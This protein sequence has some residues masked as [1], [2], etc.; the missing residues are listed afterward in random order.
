[1]NQGPEW[2][3]AEKPTIDGLKDLGYEYLTTDQHDKNR[4][5]DNHVIFR[6]ILI[7]SIQRI[8]N[9]SKEDATSAYFELLNQ[10]NNEEWNKILRGNYSR[11]V[12]GKSKKQTIKIIDYKN[13]KNNTFTVTN[14]LY[15]KAQK[16]RIPDI[17]VYIN[18]IPVVVI[19]AK[20]PLNHKDKTGEAFEQIKQ[21]ERD[22]P[23]LFYSNVF[24]VLTDGTNCLYGATGSPSQFYGT[25]K[26]PY[27]KSPNDFSDALNLGLWC[28][29]EPSRFLDLIAHYIVF[30]TKDGKTIKKIC[31]YQQFRAV[32]KMVERVVD[33][34]HKQG[35]IWHTQGSGKSLTMVF[36]ALKLKTHLNIISPQLH[37]PNI[38]VLTDRVDLDDQISK[39][40]EAC[41][42][43]NPVRVD[44]IQDLHKLIRSG[45]DGL[46]IL[47]TIFKFQG[48]NKPIE[49]SINWIVLVDECHRTQEKDLGA[50]LRATLPDS[51]FFGF[52]GTPIKKN[53][54]DTYQN[55]GI[56]GEGY[57]DKYGIDDAVADGATVPIYFTSRKT[58]WHIDEGKLDI[59]F[60]QWFGN[61][62]EEQLEKTKKKG[63][64]LATIIKH[65]QRV[66]LIAYD[67]WTHF[68]QYAIPDGL[69]AQIVGFDREAVVLYKQALDKIIAEDFH[70]QGISIEKAESMAFEMS[71]CVYSDSQEDDK[72][73]E[74]PHVSKIRS[75]LKQHY[76]DKDSERDVKINFGIK[77]IQPSFLIVCNK[78]LTGFDAPIEG[79]MYLDNPLKEH[80]L[81]QAIARTNR[82]H[83]KKSNGL[84]IDYIGVSKK[85][86]D[87]LS[88]Y[89]HDDVKNA[90]RDLDNLRSQL[91][92]AYAAVKSL[93]KGV[94]RHIKDLKSEYNAL[95]DALGTEDKW[96][97]FRRKSQEFIAVYTS[98][99]PDP[100][101]L[102]YS[103]DLKWISGFLHYATQ[104]FEKKEFVP[105]D[106]N[107][108]RKMLEEH[109]KA[110]GISTIIKLR[111]ITN[112]IF[113]DD[114][115]QE[116]KSKVDLKTA[117]IRKST[118]LKKITTDKVAENP[119]QYKKF[120]ERVLEILKKFEQGQMDAATALEHYE[121]VAKDL[122]AE[123]KAHEKSGMSSA[124][125]GI[126]K[127]LESFSSDLNEEQKSRFEE[128]ATS[129]HDMYRSDQTAPKLWQEKEQ[130][131]KSLRQQVRKGVHPLKLKDWKMIPEKVEEYALKNF[132]KV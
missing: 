118:E 56:E 104:V 113:W 21:Y 14:Q 78:L 110:T 98:L 94:K 27:P 73:S 13:T 109:L 37:N 17:I 51:I 36:A 88:S 101:I 95:V 115:E 32:N 8:N 64:T 66:E 41:G 65:P 39:T 31:R 69:K 4:D 84:I 102:D 23:R 130:L 40:F 126:F 83:D 10:Y 58:D 121:Q 18:G 24:S 52:T 1:M 11:T 71:A 103:K 49:N 35:L 50:F 67:I 127:I 43:P 2:K 100:F 81:L 74:D 16:S 79:V 54:K 108:I 91:R 72:P 105:I 28:L 114:F 15:I 34:T 61:L 82:V 62:P 46:T 47:S 132:I 120:S 63:I 70:K 68:K 30:E 92:T 124:A 75:L 106:S 116:G 97:T 85:L 7:E 12:S 55:F 86:N 57:L 42:L 119:L 3:L 131:K 29:L 19:E 26:D 38:M 44:S 112:P 99:S 59:L 33:A 53:D 6:P 77:R 128:L 117:A 96:F 125:Y 20:S 107:K 60:D 48:S 90:M 22:I 5:G 111:H 9:I 76:L 89:H 80:N 123:D 122:D 25:W 45:S 87:A 93:M 129:I